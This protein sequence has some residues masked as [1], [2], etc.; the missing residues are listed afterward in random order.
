MQ[1]SISIL[2]CILCNLQYVRKSETSFNIRLNNH[3]KDVSNQETIPACVQFRKE[4]KLYPTYKVY[5]NRGT[6]QNRKC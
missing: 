1:K 3:R 5:F 6:Y 2:E 4:E